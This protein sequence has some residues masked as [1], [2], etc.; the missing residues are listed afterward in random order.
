MGGY[1]N[2]ARPG[3]PPHG[4]TLSLGAATPTNGISPAPGFLST[5]D[6]TLEKL[7][8]MPGRTVLVHIPGRGPVPVTTDLIAHFLRKQQAQ[9][10]QAPPQLQQ[11][12]AIPVVP[13]VGARP[14]MPRAPAQPAPQPFTA[15]NAAAVSSAVL[16]A[17]APHVHRR[18]G[19]LTPPGTASSGAGPAPAPAPK[20]GT[21]AGNGTGAA[22]GP[23]PAA[24]GRKRASSGEP[25]AGGGGRR[26]ARPKGARAGASSA[27]TSPA[28]RGRTGRA[29]STEM[30]ASRP[31]SALSD[32]G[33]PPRIGQQVPQQGRRAE[34]RLQSSPLASGRPLPALHP[35][36]AAVVALARSGKILLRNNS[37][38]GVCG[39]PACPIC[40]SATAQA[41]WQPQHNSG[42]RIR[43]SLARSLM[44]PRLRPAAPPPFLSCVTA[45]ATGPRTPRAAGAAHGHPPQGPL[46]SPTADPARHLTEMEALLEESIMGLDIMHDPVGCDSWLTGAAVDYVMLQFAKAYP[47]LHFLSS[48]FLAHDLP[49]SLRHPDGVEV[50][51]LLGRRVEAHSCARPLI[52]AWNIGNLHWN[53]LRVQF[54]PRPQIQLFEPMGCV[55]SLRY[56]PHCVRLIPF[57]SLPRAGTR[58]ASSDP[59]CLSATSRAAWC[60]GWTPCGRRPGRADGSTTPRPP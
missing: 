51:D 3:Y 27:P 45:A 33:T 32:G 44:P 22:A 2:P 1:G 5:H 19:P 18:R 23:H 39:D 40:G 48:S 50:R 60:S 34:K 37:F 28:K 6:M 49:A 13:G 59:A 26:V 38:R 47:S 57:G 20:R 4:V 43:L 46:G 11:S 53:L 10:A 21:S 24:G 52:C 14:A 16:R 25:S 8:A 41:G 36:A 35:Y 15:Q 54:E 56:T 12:R 9:Q 31:L 29:S 7:A 30:G 58:A 17:S 42:I 55:A